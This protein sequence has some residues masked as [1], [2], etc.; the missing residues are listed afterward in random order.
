MRNRRNFTL[1]ELLVVIAIIAIL[2]SMLLPALQKA[3]AKAMQASCM[4]NV[5]QLSMG[6]I[7]YSDDFGMFPAYSPGPYATPY[8]Y[9]GYNAWGW[10]RPYVGDNHVYDCPTSPDPAPA[11]TPAGYHAYDGNYCWNYDGIEGSRGGI[12]RFTRPSETYMLF[13]GGD[14]SYRPGTNDW[15]GL[16]EELDL[17]W[18][19]HLEG[20]NR[21]LGQMNV[22]F[23]DGHAK[24]MTLDAFL[25]APVPDN[26][27]PWMVDFAGS[28]LVRGP[29]PYPDR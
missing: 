18:N 12:A 9:C 25:V 28:A 22:S 5:K 16:M 4:S 14:Q 23:V 2:A 7:M 17:D 6:F 26:T 10:I 21:H 11:D 29:I 24:S 20:P 8:G 13:D 27:V 1:I 3:R 15:A 19:S